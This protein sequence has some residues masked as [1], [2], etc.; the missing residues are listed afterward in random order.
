MKIYKTGWREI[1]IP[2]IR[3]KKERKK[4]GETKVVISK[5]RIIT[6][7]SRDLRII[8]GSVHYT[9]ID[10]LSWSYFVLELN[11]PIYH[12]VILNWREVK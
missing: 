1:V 2:H 10:D 9:G 3:E 6:T 12:F 8:F 11:D 4:T 5:F 7:C